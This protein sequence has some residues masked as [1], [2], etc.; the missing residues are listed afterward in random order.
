VPSPVAGLPAG[1][2]PRLVTASTPSRDGGFKSGVI[3]DGLR[4]ASV[5]AYPALPPHHAGG[6]RC[7]RAV[8][9][10]GRRAAPRGRPGPHPAAM[11]SPPGRLSGPAGPGRG[12][13]RGR[14]DRY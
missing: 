13:G 8:G 11:L 4:G 10:R 2:H 14:G 5:P 12:R 1:S 3:V 7:P 9:R 6:G